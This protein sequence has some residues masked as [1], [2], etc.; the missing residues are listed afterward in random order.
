[1][2]PK[3]RTHQRQAQYLNTHSRNPTS[4]LPELFLSIPSI[5][6]ANIYCP[7]CSLPAPCFCTTVSNNLPASYQDF[8][9]RNTNSPVTSTFNDFDISAY[10]NTSDQSAH[11]T[12]SIAFSTSAPSS[13][14]TKNIPN[15]EKDEWSHALRDRRRRSGA[16]SAEEAREVGF[17]FL[18]FTSINPSALF[19]V[20]NYT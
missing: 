13:P 4:S 19:F 15:G 8:S 10:I 11:S 9:P 3:Y 2:P 6:Y 14:V 12:P 1:M 7:S 16:M 20:L 18:F 17:T 5:D